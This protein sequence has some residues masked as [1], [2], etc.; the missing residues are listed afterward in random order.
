MLMIILILITWKELKKLLQVITP[1]KGYL[2]EKNEMNVYKNVISKMN[3]KYGIK[4][5]K[6]MIEFLS[7]N[8][9]ANSPIYPAFNSLIP[10]YH[11]IL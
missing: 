8:L 3:S 4:N 9:G 5:I 2:V 10:L 7:L 6:Y 11:E 1:I